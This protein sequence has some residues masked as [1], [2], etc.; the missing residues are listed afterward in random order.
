MVY[1]N[2]RNEHIWPLTIKWLHIFESFHLASLQFKTFDRFWTIHLIL[3]SMPEIFYISIWW[4]SLW[5]LCTIQF[6]YK[7]FSLF[8]SQILVC[9]M[10]FAPHYLFSR[11]DIGWAINHKQKSGKIY[12]HKSM[13][14]SRSTKP[15][16][17]HSWQVWRSI[18]N[19]HINVKI[20]PIMIWVHKNKLSL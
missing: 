17:N 9:A 14:V 19:N 5:L 12:R 20:F 4:L 13:H 6:H 2:Y 1:L 15:L 3:R 16:A 10:V 18:Y 7:S 11:F 8:S